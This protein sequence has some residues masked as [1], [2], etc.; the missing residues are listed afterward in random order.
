MKKFIIYLSFCAICIISCDAGIDKSLISY[1][2][3]LPSP[4]RKFNVYLYFVE[5]PMSFGSGFTAINILD[6]RKELV[7]SDRDFLNLGADV[8]PF[9]IKWKDDA[10]LSVKCI[11]S[12]MD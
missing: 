10:T 8:S 4:D 1:I 5:S 11:T 3:K 12:Q 9:W 6:S 7:P 2:D